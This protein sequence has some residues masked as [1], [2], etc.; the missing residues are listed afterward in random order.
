LS[1]YWPFIIPGLVSGAIYSLLGVGV[2]LTY[3]TTGVFNFAFGAQAYAAAVIYY[4][5]RV[6]AGWAAI[7][8][9][10]MAA[11]VAS[12]LIGYLL[13]RMVFRHL[14]TSPVIVRV[15]VGIGMLTAIPAIVSIFTG[16]VKGRFAAPSLL[17]EQRRYYQWGSLNLDS[18][19]L[20][21]IVI[22]VVILVSLA[23]FMRF[24][25]VGL[26][27]RAVVESG[28]LAELHGVGAPGINT[29]AWLISSALAGIAGV[30]LAPLFPAVSPLPFTLL[31]MAA[32]A[33]AVFGRLRSLPLT[34]LGSLLTGVG[35]NL[36]IKWL[37]LGAKLATGLRPSF[38]FLFLF[39]LLIVT[40]SLQKEKRATDP[41]AGV[42]PPPTLAHASI[43]KLPGTR[44]QQIMVSLAVLGA[45][46]LLLDDY[47]CGV[48][49]GAALMSIVFLSLMLLT[50]QGGYIS[51]CHGAFVG[52]GA[53]VAA[54][55]AIQQDV[56]IVV[57]ALVGG[58]V[59]GV[60]GLLLASPSLRLGELSLALATFGFGL[61]CENMIFNQTWAFGAQNGLY[62]P[63]PS[64]GGIDMSDNRPFLVLCLVLLGLVVVLLR[65]LLAGTTGQFAV[66]VRG[67][68]T[69]AASVGI[70]AV[71][72]RLAIFTLSAALAGFAGGML[73]SLNTVVSPTSFTSGTSL[74]WLVIVLVIGV[75]T[76]RGAV[77]AGVIFVL[78]PTV[79]VHL[80][81]SLGLLQFALFGLGV[82]SLAKHPEGALEYFL[83][84]PA[85][86]QERTRQLSGDA[87]AEEREAAI[88]AA[89]ALPE[90]EP[91][92]V[93]MSEGVLRTTEQERIDRRARRR[94]LTIEAARLR[95]RM[96]AYP[97][98]FLYILTFAFAID[99]MARSLLAT[100]LDDI[101]R[102]FGIQY[103]DLGLLN[104]GYSVV[105][106]LSV[107]PFGRLVDRKN[108][109]WIVALGFVPWTLAMIWQGLAPTFLMMFVARLFLGSIEGTHGPATPSLLGDYYPV[110]RRNRVFGTF[111]VGASL[112]A[113]LGILFGGALAGALGWRAAF[114]VFGLIGAVAGLAVVKV[115]REPDRGL[116]DAL[117]GLEEEIAAIER[118]EEREA[119]ALQHPA[120]A[121]DILGPSLGSPTSLA[122]HELN[123]SIGGATAEHDYR[124]DSIKD[125]LRSLV[126]NRTFVLLLSGQV[127]T[128]FF[129]GI[130]GLWA[131]TYF[132][133]YHELSIAGAS[134][135]VSLLSISLI[136]GTLHAG[137]IGDR[138]V[139]RG[140]PAGRVRLT[141]ITRVLFFLVS[142][143]AWSSSQL[144]VAI[145]FFL[146]SGYLVGL[147]GPL[148]QAMSIDLVVARVRGQALGV[149]T[150]IRAGSTASGP[151]LLGIVSD[152][153]GLRQGVLLLTPFM[154]L[155]AFL[156][157]VAQRSYD[158]DFA[159]AQQETVRQTVLEGR[160]QSDQGVGPMVDD[161]VA[162]AS[163]ASSA[164][165]PVT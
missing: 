134:G 29:L 154:L 144:A 72:L 141:A 37:D 106:A 105:A 67:S 93:G 65:R 94:H 119:E 69:A 61:L 54:Q 148:T 117:Y 99:G 7:P 23:L 82:V 42:A 18:D 16:G 75:Y 157:F 73:G 159:F 76:I 85:R 136:L 149:S 111:G 133:R 48:F 43:G 128:D 22:A 79:V 143:V 96:P 12:P 14:R 80:P 15:A 156:T 109:V 55:L 97:V 87:T 24:S 129:I 142:L 46:L 56:P 139:A 84:L 140:T 6:E 130:I 126:G 145:P 123:V 95:A 151:L 53:F 155:A 8:A 41:M 83:T 124:E 162:V 77:T 47:W 101:R 44:L 161:L 131:I 110:R 92:P 63:R 98:K 9:V 40:K 5:L 113:T 25:D 127:A 88:L 138:L 71:P 57:G 31:L 90:V 112:G 66:A 86:M 150:A 1:S 125:T 160:D 121:D 115:L 91:D 74:Y 32:L 33:G 58:V 118:V 10:V 34:V 64:F 38:P 35:Q 62:P 152:L 3:Q 122:S 11:L 81:A 51:L 100:S 107:L 60:G 137:V 116:Q 68:E 165:D 2:V 89:L 45:G 59:A 21:V 36:V 13:D 78:L 158:Q 120:F 19:Q 163:E 50:G 39:G 4:D 70:N 30:I 104:A 164:A 28:L 147:T 26:R 108:R 27:M 132:R 146:A 52:T 153:Y 17:Y 102:D 49:A 135:V 20:V 114:I 103:T